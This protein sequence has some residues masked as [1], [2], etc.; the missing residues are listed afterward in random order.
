MAGDALV[1]QL[2]LRGRG[3]GGDGCCGA[4]VLGVMDAGVTGTV[5]LG[6]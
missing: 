6:K 1:A 5:G 3:G 4:E 2:A